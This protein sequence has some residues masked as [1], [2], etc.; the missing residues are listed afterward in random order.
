LL[1]DLRYLVVGPGYH[2]RPALLLLGGAPIVAVGL[3]AGLMVGLLAAV[4]A[5]LLAR[6]SWRRRLLALAGIGGLAG[7][8]GALGGAADVVFAHGHNFAAVALWWWWRPRRGALRWLPVA[9]F[10]GAMALFLSELGVSWAAGGVGFGWSLGH[11]GMEYQLWRL[12]PGIDPAL[13]IRLVLLFAFAQ[14]IHYAV[15]LHLIPDDDRE[16]ATPATFARSYRELC[17]VMGPWVVGIAGALALG[18]VGWAIFDL[19]AANHGYFRLARFHGH[20][21]LCAATLLLLEGRR[22]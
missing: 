12:T 19:M 7:I 14:A 1:A 17:A 2:R 15:W 18:F 13:G 20:L 3:G 21:E 16:R 11:M 9:L 8:L 5:A 22:R 6:T 10:G 4:A